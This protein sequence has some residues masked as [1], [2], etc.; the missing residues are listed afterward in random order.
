MTVLRTGS[1]RQYSE[2]WGKAF[3]VKASKSK[4][5]KS[6]SKNQKSKSGRNAGRAKS[7][8]R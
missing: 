8:K 6:K 7:S 2:N 1:S 4:S 3:G 5:I